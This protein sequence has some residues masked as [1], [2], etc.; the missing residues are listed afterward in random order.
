MNYT[1]QQLTA[2]VV[3]GGLR[4]V[5]AGIETGVPASTVSLI[6]KCWDANPQNRPSFNDIVLELDGILQQRKE[7]EKQDLSLQESSISR[8]H[9]VI[10]INNL[11]TYQE[12]INWSTQG[13][14]LSKRASV[15]VY[16]GFRIWLDSLDD[17]L[18][19]HP[20]LSWGSFATCGRRE[21]MEDTH[22]LMPYICNEK[23]IHVFGIFDGH[24]GMQNRDTPC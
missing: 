3:S 14:S 21:S 10:D 8:G 18:T 24:R 7:L 4:P 22:F 11:Q 16:S 2:A 23:D 19:Y 20:V 1:E 12:N 15:G 13:E 9:Q 6:Q 17:S 5:L